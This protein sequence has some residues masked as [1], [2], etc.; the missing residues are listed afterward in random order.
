MTQVRIQGVFVGHR[1][2]FLA[3]GRA[4]A[5]HQLR[6]RVDRTFAFEEARAAFEH[7]A[8]GALGLSPSGEGKRIEA[9]SGQGRGQVRFGC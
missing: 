4:I 1:E 9:R 6:P 5:Q 2:G 7:L 8:S 3:M